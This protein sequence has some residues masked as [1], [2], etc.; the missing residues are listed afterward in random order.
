MPGGEVREALVS[1]CKRCISG[2]SGTFVSADETLKR[3]GALGT[4]DRETLLHWMRLGRR[5]STPL[6]QAW[7]AFRR[8]PAEARDVIAALVREEVE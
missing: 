4:A 7:S 8:L 2:F 3:V 5:K 6:D 1:Q